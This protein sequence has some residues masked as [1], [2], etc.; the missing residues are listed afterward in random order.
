MGGRASKEEGS[1]MNT[2]TVD[3]SASPPVTTDVGATAD[4]VE[5]AKADSEPTWNKPKDKS[6][7]NVVVFRNDPDWSLVEVLRGNDSN[8]DDKEEEGDSRVTEALCIHVDPKACSRVVKELSATLPLEDGLSHL[9]R[10]RRRPLSEA[11]EAS[12]ATTSA[13]PKDDE[14]K[15]SPANVMASATAKLTSLVSQSMSGICRSPTASTI[16]ER[17]RKRQKKSSN[18]NF[19]LE[20]LIGTQSHL[21]NQR[22]EPSNSDSSSTP[23]THLDHP[24]IREFGP[25]HKV[26]VP[27]YAPRS[28]DEWKEHNQTWPTLYHPL[29]FEDHLR[30]KQRQ[31][32]ALSEKEIGRIR[33]FMEKSISTKSVLIVD[34]NRCSSNNGNEDN[35]VGVVSVSRDEQVLQD[36]QKPRSPLLRVANNPL[37]TPIL[38]ALQGVSREERRVTLNGSVHDDG[39]EID[40]ESPLVASH[41]NGTRTKPI[42]QKS[43]PKQRS[44]IDCQNEKH[45]PDG[46]RIKKFFK[47]Q[48]AWFLG[49]IRAYD[50]KTKFYSI[51]YDDGDTEELEHHEIDTNLSELPNSKYQEGFRYEV[52]LVC[53]K[54]KNEKSKTKS[55]KYENKGHGTAG[56]WFTGTIQSKWFYKPEHGKGRWQYGVFYDDFEEESEDVDVEE[57]YIDGCVEK[58]KHKRGRKPKRQTE[59]RAVRDE[60][61]CVHRQEEFDHGNGNKNENS[62]STDGDKA[63][64][65]GAVSTEKGN[66]GQQQQ[67]QQQ[68]PK[69]EPPKRQYIC[70]GYDMYTFY[71]PTIFEAM[72]CLHSRLRRLI[73]FV[74]S[75]DSSSA[76]AASSMDA[77][78]TNCNPTITSAV[79]GLGISKQ[80]V[81][82]LQGTNHNYR[83][84]EYR[85]S[86][87]LS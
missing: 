55:P 29:K 56:R 31:E 87:Y 15:S 2:A 71:E 49:S 26:E 78:K 43:Q 76:A 35:F 72:A 85:Q 37:A 6:I 67:Q 62:L 84:F 1:K 77:S 80:G 47:D 69:Q 70:T 57:E 30:E 25:L 42:A 68:Q 9:K 34:P 28:E 21:E 18:Q 23:S 32:S 51:V 7:S 10:V 50:S 44:T 54:K 20:L 53:T 65:V 81:H 22:K 16:Q 36:S 75:S 39:D 79:W 3:S 19:V 13:S 48:R 24:V 4:T 12:K 27:R 66:E 73:Y 11:S 17:P 33:S 64:Q 52:Y 60:S 45:H 58:A 82:H 5:T 46:T 8:E 40:N 38:L 83:A 14:P 61:W 74:P 86:G 41:H 59:I 63:K